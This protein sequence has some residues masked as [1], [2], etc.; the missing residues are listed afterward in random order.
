MIWILF[1]GIGTVG[2]L[3]NFMVNSYLA[4]KVT[5]RFT[6]LVKEVTFYQTY[7]TGKVTK[8]LPFLPIR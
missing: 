4:G 7:P 5:L 6:N 2:K 1:T 8:L 3:G